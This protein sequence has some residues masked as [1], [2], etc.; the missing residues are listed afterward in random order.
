M[1]ATLH[2]LW[3]ECQLLR[4]DGPQGAVMEY[5]RMGGVD[6]IL[7]CLFSWNGAGHAQ[8]QA[9]NTFVTRVEVLPHS[10]GLLLPTILPPTPDMRS[11][12][13]VKYGTSTPKAPDVCDLTG[14]IPAVESTELQV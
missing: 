1:A 6:S 13:R 12:K 14:D 7:D 11:R 2:N 5:S 8:L 9:S 10:T 4:F 3:R